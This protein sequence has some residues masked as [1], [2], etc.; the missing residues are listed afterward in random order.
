MQEDEAWRALSD[1]Q[2]QAVRRAM[3]YGVQHWDWACP[4]LFGLEREE[5]IRSIVTWPRA[6][7]GTAET[8]TLAVMGA[9]REILFGAS[10]PPKGELVGLIGLSYEQACDL[11]AVVHSIAE[12]SAGSAHR[13]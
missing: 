10:R 2:Q 8:T 12:G 4:T 7:A 13:V 11:V 6:E 3:E 1:S 9:L 5:I